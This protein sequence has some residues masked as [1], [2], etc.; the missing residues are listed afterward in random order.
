MVDV[1]VT[2]TVAIWLPIAPSQRVTLAVRLA[3]VQ[4]GTGDAVG[5]GVG[6]GVSDGVGVGA[7]AE[8]A[9]SGDAA[10][11]AS[12]DGTTEG[13]AE[14]PADGETAATA[15][16]DGNCVMDTSDEGRALPPQPATAR[17]AATP[18][19]SAV[20]RNGISRISG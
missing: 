5:F 4:V 8:D 9:A 18:I 19:A 11:D 13:V 20:R 2:V 14:E 17:S 1:S 12:A 15:D 3:F 7:G 6:E 10:A 16:D